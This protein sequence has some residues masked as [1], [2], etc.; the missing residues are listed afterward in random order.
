VAE[1]IL[2]NV[3]NAARLSDET[4]VAALSTADAE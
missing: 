4:C 3:T 1:D 2:A